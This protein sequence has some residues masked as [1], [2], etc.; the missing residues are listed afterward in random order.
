MIA[1]RGRTSSVPGS[2]DRPTSVTSPAGMPRKVTG[3]PTARPCSDSPW[4]IPVEGERR[5]HHCRRRL[6]GG[7]RRVEGD[8]AADQRLQGSAAQLHAAGVHRDVQAADV[9]EASLR[10][11]VLVVGRIDEQLDID[12]LA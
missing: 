8:A 6:V 2:Y 11:D 9:P 4:A 7:G 12:R 1:T 10:A 3:A 5:A